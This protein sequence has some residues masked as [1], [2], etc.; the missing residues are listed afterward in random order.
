MRTFVHTS[1]CFVKWRRISIIRLYT[2]SIHISSSGTSL[3]F[4][5]RVLSLLSSRMFFLTSK[6]DSWVDVWALAKKGFRM[7]PDC[8]VFNCEKVMLI[9]LIWKSWVFLGQIQPKFFVN[10]I[11]L[12]WLL[13]ENISSH[14]PVNAVFQ[15]AIFSLKP[16]DL[17]QHVNTFSFLPCILMLSSFKCSN[18]PVICKFSNQTI[19]F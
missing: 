5:L 7:R 14:P 17:S 12:Y 1:P 13:L 9:F 19:V 16:F 8:S 18:M 6:D 11:V 3:N 4:N 2:S 10:S 15:S